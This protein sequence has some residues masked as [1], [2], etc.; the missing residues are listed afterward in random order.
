[1]VP[2][3]DYL[4]KKSVIPVPKT[5]DLTGDS[6]SQVAK[7]APT[8][9]E[10]AKHLYGLIQSDVNVAYTN[11]FGKYLSLLFVIPRSQKYMMHSER[12]PTRLER[13]YQRQGACSWSADNCSR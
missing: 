1:M 7:V 9:T 13:Q 11:V 5:I 8:G 10:I 12:S 3:K 6:N 2:V 4:L